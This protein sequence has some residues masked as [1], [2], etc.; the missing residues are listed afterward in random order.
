MVGYAVSIV[1]S[2]YSN[3]LHL[4][5]CMSGCLYDI[6]IMYKPMSNRR[7]GKENLNEKSDEKMLNLVLNSN[8]N[9]GDAATAIIGGGRRYCLRQLDRL[10]RQFGSCVFVIYNRIYD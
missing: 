5:T 3:L 7:R 8:I 10:Y 1:Q 6:K 9:V 4:L 2:L